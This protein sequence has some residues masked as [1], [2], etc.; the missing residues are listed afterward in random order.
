MKRRTHATLATL[1][2]LSTVLLLG[3]SASAQSQLERLV[4]EGQMSWLAGQ[5]TATTD[6]GQTITLTYRWQLNKNMISVAF[7]MGDYS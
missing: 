5:W 6:E 2:V 4:E 7:K 3:S 1:L